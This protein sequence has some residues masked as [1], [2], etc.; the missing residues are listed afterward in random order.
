[1]FKNEWLQ[2]DGKGRS[3]ARLHLPCLSA[4]LSL[5]PSVH[6][7][8]CRMKDPFLQA[9]SVCP[10]PRVLHRKGSGLSLL[11]C[12][13]AIARDFQRILLKRLPYVFSQAATEVPSCSS[14]PLDLSVIVI[15]LLT[16]PV[17]LLPYVSAPSKDVP[18]CSKQTPQQLNQTSHKS[19][20][21]CCQ[22]SRKTS[23][24]KEKRRRDND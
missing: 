16:S 11:H 10:K 23:C 9:Q 22:S 4:L 18:V 5:F 19:F 1:M 8:T 3:M 2:A 7:Q 15:S 20:L 12:G 13:M 21:S 14:L 17:C 24:M 6:L